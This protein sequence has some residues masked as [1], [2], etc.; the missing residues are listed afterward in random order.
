MRVYNLLFFMAS[1][2]ISGGALRASP[3]AL[4]GARVGAKVLPV[5]S[6]SA[7]GTETAKRLRETTD[8]AM[9]TVRRFVVR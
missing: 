4:T 6:L 5:G 8:V 3:S 9:N 2:P 1:L 7:R